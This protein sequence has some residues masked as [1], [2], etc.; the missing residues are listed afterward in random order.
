LPVLPSTL[1]I[2]HCNRNKLICLPPLPSTLKELICYDNKLTLLPLLPY[3]LEILYFDNNLKMDYYIKQDKL[4]M[5]NYITT[6]RKQIEILNP[7]RNTFYT[8]KYKKQLKNWLWMRIRE[9]KIK[10]KYHPS[11]LMTMLKGREEDEMTLDE[12]DKLIE[13]W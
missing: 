13:N 12:L 2:L 3:T 8:I 5:I 6:I 1:E 4:S 10:Y 11:N 7:F 9:P